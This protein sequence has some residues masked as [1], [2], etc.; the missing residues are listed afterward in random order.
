MAVI[1]CGAS[2][3]FQS[4]VDA[5]KES[6][7][8][9]EKGEYKQALEPLRLAVQTLPKK[10]QTWN[11]LGMAF[12]GDN[13]LEKSI[14]AYTKALKLDNK[15][16]PGYFNLGTVYLERKDFQRAILSFTKYLQL[17]PNEP[18]GW[19]KLG[20]AQLESRNFSAAEDSFKRVIR[21]TLQHPQASN[22][23]GVIRLY[24]NSAKEAETQFLDALNIQNDYQPALLNL[25]IVYHKYLD[26]PRWAIAKYREYLEL[27]PRPAN[28]QEVEETLKR[29]EAKFPTTGAVLPLPEL[30]GSNSGNPVESE[31]PSQLPESSLASVRR[32]SENAAS[33]KTFSELKKKRA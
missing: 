29:L 21:L 11:L 7:R 24:Q 31:S 33:E 25:A 19:L 10:P 20:S 28:W 12:Q 17:N 9:V 5:L 14:Q 32:S 30:P 13:K 2:G 26:R 3:C 18:E 15:F 16:A 1:C 27:T 23:L 6:E 8:L 22:G 4:G